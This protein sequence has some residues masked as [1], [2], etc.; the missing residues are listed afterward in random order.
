MV[1]KSTCK[2]CDEKIKANAYICDQCLRLVAVQKGKR[3]YMR[4]RYAWRSLILILIALFW[5]YVLLTGTAKGSYWLKH[6]MTIT[7]ALV[8]YYNIKEY[9]V[10]ARLAYENYDP[11]AKD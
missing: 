4:N 11:Y 8:L 9:F 6:V 5:V 10:W 7:L 3:R 1:K 2:D